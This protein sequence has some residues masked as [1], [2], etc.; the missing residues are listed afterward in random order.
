VTTRTWPL[1][2]FLLPSVLL[3]LVYSYL[4]IGGIIIAFQDFKPWK[5]I[6]GSPFIGMDNFKAMFTGPYAV[7]SIR[8]TIVI[9]SLKLAF[10]WV[11]PLAFALLLNEVRFIRAKRVIQTLVYLPHFLSWVILGGIFLEILSTRGIVNAGLQ[12]VGLA[13][14][15]FLFNG[16]WFRGVLVAT[17]VWKE[18][19]FGTIVYLAGIAGVNLNLYEAADIDG[20][21]QLGKA[22]HVTLPSILPIA[23]VLATLSLGGILNAGFDQVLNLYNPMVYEQADIIDTFVYRIGLVQGSFGLATAVGLFKSAVGLVLISV[24]YWLAVRYGNYRIF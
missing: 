14:V 8:N 11:I 21:G 7:Q 2:A 6:L 9:A 18:F 17:D 4:P 3:L 12:A 15:R 1:H 23:V 24:T 22:W 13:P 19:G 5:G 16:G 20:A 10:G